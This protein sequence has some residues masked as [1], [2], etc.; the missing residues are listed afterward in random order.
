MERTVRVHL[1]I[2]GVGL[3]L[4]VGVSIVTS[5]YVASRAYEKRW[6]MQQSAHRD[7]TVKG[8]ARL[9][10]ESDQADW[11]VTV[12][13]EG[14]T[15][16]EAYA[17][18]EAAET[19]VRE[20]LSSGGL[21]ASDF[22]ASSIETRYQYQRNEKNE[23]TNKIE[24]YVLTRD[25]RVSTSQVTKVSAVSGSI[26]QLLKE[27]LQVISASPRFS[28]SKLPELRITLSGEAAKDARARAEE[29]ASKA[30]CSITDIRDVNTGPIQVT[31]PNS[32]D[33]SSSGS[34][35]TSTISKDVWMSVTATFGVD[36]D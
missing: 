14:A 18:I 32:T 6:R 31:A 27:N 16:A 19:R 9:R 12:R 8:S 4:V 11:T 1:A 34:Y 23:P 15:L 3:A 36:K 35:D 29:L 28:Y 33:V 22:T 30:G 26:T 21:S 5:T 20:L 2:G 25:L 7:L 13:G 17:Q 24:S 10:V